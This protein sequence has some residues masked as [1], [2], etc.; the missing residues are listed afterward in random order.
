MEKGREESLIYFCRRRTGK[1]DIH[2]MRIMGLDIGW[3]VS[4]N[5]QRGFRRN[6][7]DTKVN[8]HLL[9]EFALCIYR[10]DRKNP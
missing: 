9:S 1:K 10:E 4:E 8:T 3:G 6:T 5:L 7:E 2:V